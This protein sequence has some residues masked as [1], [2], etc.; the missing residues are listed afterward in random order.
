MKPKYQQTD[1]NRARGK[2]FVMA[3]VYMPAFPNL[4]QR[5]HLFTGDL[6]T[7]QKYLRLVST[8]HGSILTYISTR[9]KP[10]FSVEIFGKGS[11]NNLENYLS[12][13]HTS[14]FDYYSPRYKQLINFLDNRKKFILVE[15]TD[16]GCHILGKW[17]R[18]PKIY[19][20]IFKEYD[21]SMPIVRIYDKDY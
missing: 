18:L 1:L 7:I 12:F 9:D 17:R 4:P 15:N 5:T 20:P 2:A 21:D 11:I 13:D 16:T 8:C 19:L 6:E 14:L 3:Y 10:I